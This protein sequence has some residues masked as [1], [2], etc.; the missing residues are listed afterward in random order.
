MQPPSPTTFG[1]ERYWGGLTQKVAVSETSYK[2]SSWFWAVG[3][4]KSPALGWHQGASQLPEQLT[5]ESWRQQSPKP[6]M[7]NS[8]Q[9][10]QRDS[11]NKRRTI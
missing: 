4:E 5:E 9:G 8:K 3:T 10:P 1:E 6:R 7:P 11:S 2:T